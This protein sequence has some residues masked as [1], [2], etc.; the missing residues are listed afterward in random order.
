M[1]VAFFYEGETSFKFWRENQMPIEITQLVSVLSFLV[2]AFA[3]ARNLKLDTKSDQTE[4][5][6]VIVK[7]ENINDNIKEVK[8]DMKDIITDMD[9][10]KERLTAVAASAKSAHKRIDNLHNEHPTEE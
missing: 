6:T 7:L 9:K 1:V 8:I 10:V 3:L 5:T 4:L 2:A